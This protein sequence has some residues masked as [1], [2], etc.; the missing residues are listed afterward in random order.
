MLRGP[1][2]NLWWSELMS[3]DGAA[4]PTLWRTTRAVALGRAFEAIR[5]LWD[6]P[7][8]VTSGY[9]SAAWNTH[10]GGVQG[11]YHRKG[12]ALDLRPPAGISV[13]AFRDGILDIAHEAGIRGV[14]YADASKGGFVHVDLR[15]SPIVVTWSY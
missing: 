9:R 15:D 12:L 5:A 4:Y 3:H 7:I 10:V 14:G 11:S 1:T 13:E 8:E 2:L 6:M